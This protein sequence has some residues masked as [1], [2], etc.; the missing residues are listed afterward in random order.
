MIAELSH[1]QIGD[2]SIGYRRA[3]RGPALVLL[4]GG[5]ME[6]GALEPLV[7]QLRAAF[8][9]VTFDLRGHGGTGPVPFAFSSSVRDVAYDTACSCLKYTSKANR[10]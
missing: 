6:Q 10:S 9:V 2:L 1:V 4:H 7:E 5:G 3:G 8:R